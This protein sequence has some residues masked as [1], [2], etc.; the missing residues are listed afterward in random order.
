MA[1]AKSKSSFTLTKFT[2]NVVQIAGTD[3]TGAEGSIILHADEYV[4]LNQKLASIKAEDVFDDAIEAHFKDITDAAEALKAARENPETNSE[5]DITIKEGVEGV[6]SVSA[7]RIRPSLETIIIRLVEAGDT[8][9]LRWV[10]EALLI[11][12]A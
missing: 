6:E 8:D 2:G 7:V 3:V 5:F 10:N 11:T 12:E 9:R 4:R 1:P